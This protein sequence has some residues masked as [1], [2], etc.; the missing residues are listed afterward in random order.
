[1]QRR[2]EVS[3]WGEV[4]EREEV[5]RRREEVPR[6]REEGSRWTGGQD[7]RSHLDFPNL[8]HIIRREIQK[9]LHSLGE[10]ERTGRRCRRREEGRS[11][12]ERSWGRH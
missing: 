11:Y 2:E 5:H 4:P 6:R 7:R 12:S 8:S 3:R 10:E 9:A 1:M